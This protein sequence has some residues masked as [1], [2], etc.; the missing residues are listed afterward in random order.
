M[1]ILT[2]R[3][4]VAGF[5]VTAGITVLAVI[6]TY[7]VWSDAH[8]GIHHAQKNLVDEIVLGH[9]RRAGRLILAYADSLIPSR[10]SSWLAIILGQDRVRRAFSTVSDM[11][12]QRYEISTLTKT[13][14]PSIE[15][16]PDFHRPGYS[17]QWLRL[18]LSI[19]NA[20]KRAPCLSLANSSPSRMVFDDHPPGN[21]LPDAKILPRAP[22]A[23]ERSPLA[24]VGAAGLAHGRNDPHGVFQLV[25]QTQ[26]HAA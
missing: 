13:V 4:V 8:D 12:H 1:N 25:Q 14:S 9:T 17:H 21:S 7:F 2:L 3:Q 6:A 10:I 15:R 20:A 26:P 16:R 11:L 5:V 18:S 24:H 22:L 19:P 23:K